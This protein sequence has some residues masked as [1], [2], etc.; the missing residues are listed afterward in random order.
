MTTLNSINEISSSRTSLIRKELLLF[1]TPVK[2][3]NPSKYGI[4]F[5]LEQRE[6]S[7]AIHMV[8][9]KAMVKQY[10]FSTLAASK[11]SRKNSIV[12]ENSSPSSITRLIVSKKKLVRNQKLLLGLDPIS[13]ENDEQLT[14]KT[15]FK[16]RAKNALRK[17]RALGL[18]ML[19]FRGDNI[20][21]RCQDVDEADCEMTSVKLK[22]DTNNS[23][24]EKPV[25]K[26][27]IDKIFSED[28]VRPR[29]DSIIQTFD[30]ITTF[31]KSLFSSNK[32][33]EPK[34]ENKEDDM[35]PRLRRMSSY[36]DSLSEGS[37]TDEDGQDEETTKCG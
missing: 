26:S 20:T 29:K 17:I 36:Y 7:N 25:K 21:P 5:I 11:L 8:K 10:C 9:K 3:T 16:E 34:E 12:L 13:E 14:S 32:V 15:S 24:N 19:E 33:Q 28:K 23:V 27:S 35:L 37:L 30:N 6:Q 31:V 22:T 1:E 2:L 4:A 18:L